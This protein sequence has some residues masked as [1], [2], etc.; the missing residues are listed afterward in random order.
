LGEVKNLD[1]LY[2]SLVSEWTDS[3]AIVK[4]QD[5]ETSHGE[6]RPV[7][8]LNDQLPVKGIDQ[9]QLR[10]MYKDSM[11]YLNDDILCKVDRAAM[12]VSLETRIPFLDHRVAETAWSLSVDQKI[13]GNV[14]KIV[15]RDVLYKYVPRELIDRPKA[16]FGIPVGD[17]LKGPL[18]NWAEEL[19]NEKRLESEGYFYSAPI[20]KAWTEHLS[21][22][23]DHTPKLW[24]V[25]MF[26]AWLENNFQQS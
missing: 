8:V 13:Q 23:C 12:S 22:R 17:W 25:L 4:F 1:D 3:E 26:Q 19:L 21:G 2:M 11:S 20:Q 10:M 16:G 5:D 6:F 9:S 7:S 18:R 24:T 15:L 14:G